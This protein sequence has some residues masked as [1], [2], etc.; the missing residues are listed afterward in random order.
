MMFAER[1]L[2]R[3]PPATSAT[4][5]TQREKVNKS[6]ALEVATA[7]LRGCN[8]KRPKAPGSKNTASGS[9]GVATRKPSENSHFLSQVAEVA[10]V[11]GRITRQPKHD[12]E[13]AYQEDFHHQ[14]Q[15][16][17]SVAVPRA[18]ADL[19][20]NFE[21]ASALAEHD[22]GLSRYDAECQAFAETARLVPGLDDETTDQAEV[23]LEAL[24]PAEWVLGVLWINSMPAPRAFPERRWI[25]FQADAVI[26]ASS[27]GR[28]A[29]DAGWKAAELFGLSSGAPWYNWRGFG[30]I[31]MLNGS[32]ITAIDANIITITT[33]TGATQ[34]YRRRSTWD[35]A[36]PA[37]ALGR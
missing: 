25:Q 15:V 35:D 29:I 16:A 1:W 20:D 32:T 24:C 17:K 21:E 3:A 4:S 33:E 23:W 9:K 34:R 10:E 22:G 27:W 37:W 36:V 12:G 26:F 31:P 8:L 28:Q 14:P 6:A 18:F 5:A 13:P 30:V 11:A 19:L 7:L 2:N